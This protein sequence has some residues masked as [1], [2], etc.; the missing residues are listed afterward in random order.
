MFIARGAFVV[1]KLAVMSS[2]RRSDLRREQAAYRRALASRGL[3][4]TYLRQS[5][6]EGASDA[7]FDRIRPLCYAGYGACTE[8]SA[9]MQLQEI[10]GCRVLPLMLNDDRFEHLETALCPLGSGHVLVYMNA[11][12]AHSQTLLRQ[13]ID[14][15]HLIEIG[16]DDA[17]DFACSAI[18]VG[19]ALVLHGASR[20]LRERLRAIGYRIF[21]TGLDEF[22]RAGGSA[23][24]LALR[25]DDGPALRG[26]SAP[27]I[28]ETVSERFSSR[29]RS[30]EVSSEMA[31]S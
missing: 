17:L 9:T 14:A 25:L 3:A 8:R 30:H 31:A 7:L 29:R 26:E 19:D 4:T 16:V 1:G 6:F 23:K 21:R 22:V 24:T 15:A 20:T 5:Y 11:F 2:F 18:E 10:V 27:R 13:T 12:S 28:V